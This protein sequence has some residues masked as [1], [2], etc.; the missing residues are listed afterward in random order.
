MLVNWLRPF[1]DAI[2]LSRLDDSLTDHEP[3][4][5]AL[6]A[7]WRA[8]ASD[9]QSVADRRRRDPAQPS[10]STCTSTSRRHVRR[11]PGRHLRA[12]SGGGGLG[13]TL[14]DRQAEVLLR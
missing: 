8:P 14:D 10:A 7:S 4:L 2:L 3:P 11:I 1:Q 5:L 13:S 6:L 12:S 9:A